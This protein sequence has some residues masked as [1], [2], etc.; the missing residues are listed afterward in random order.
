MDAK[1]RLEYTSSFMILHLV[2][3]VCQHPHKSIGLPHD[4][5]CLPHEPIG[6]LYGWTL[7]TLCLHMLA[8]WSMYNKLSE[9]SGVSICE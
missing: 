2:G 3:D 6:L 9:P 5:V 1:F 7:S 4:T 8:S